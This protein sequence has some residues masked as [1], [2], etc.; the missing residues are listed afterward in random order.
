M[1]KKDLEFLAVA[2][3]ASKLS[4][5]KSRNVGGILTINDKIVSIESNGAPDNYNA[6]ASCYRK[7]NGFVSG[8]MLD[9]CY[10]IHA[11]QRLVFDALKQNID[12]KNCTVY[13]NCTPCMTCAKFL[14]H[15]GVKRVVTS[16][17]YPDEFSIEFMKKAGLNL[18]VIENELPPIKDEYKFLID[19]KIEKR[20]KLYKEIV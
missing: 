13:I 14:V 6:C 9:K 10:A 12:L 18:E 17:Y 1:K 15:F 8:T 2:A 11:E 20:L 5:C 4:T 7:D 19:S 16:S 3:Y